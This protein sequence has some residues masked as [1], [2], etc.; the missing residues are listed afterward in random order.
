[1]RNATPIHGLM[2]IVGTALLLSGA[3]C[4]ASADIRTRYAVEVARCTANERAIVDREGTSLE[5]DRE[6]LEVERARC[7][8]ALAAIG[9]AP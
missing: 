4:G 1:M 3:S 5:Q 8:A 6:D 2:V 7:D 9:G